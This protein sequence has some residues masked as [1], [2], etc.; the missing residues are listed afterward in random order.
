MVEEDDLV[1]ELVYDTVCLYIIL[2]LIIILINN[3]VLQR[4]WKP[5]Y[6]LLNQLKNYRIG[7]SKMLPKI[8]TDTK[9]FADLQ[10]AVNILLHHTIETYEQ[11]KSFIANAAHELQTPLAIVLNKLELLVEKESL[12]D[13]QAESIANVMHTIERLVRLN[14]SLLLLTK[15]ENKQFLN[16]QNNSLNKAVNEIL[17]DLNEIAEYKNI[18]FV[19]TETS[20]ENLKIDSSLLNI[21]LANLLRNAIFP[22]V[23]NGT[24]NITISKNTLKISNTGTAKAIND[25]K[26]FLRFYKSDN[27]TNGSGLGLAIVKAIC[28]LYGFSIYYRFENS[29]HFFEINFK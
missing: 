13:N 6:S 10:H 17:I 25:K 16:N 19:F 15:I 9:E 8:K 29:L 14:K 2:L 12:K 24:V 23:E 3:F 28:D 7:N 20:N 5:F 21:L 27:S 22:N 4:L 1:K 18:K 26:I 11:Q